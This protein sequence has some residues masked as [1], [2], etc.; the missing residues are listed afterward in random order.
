MQGQL[1]VN[2]AAPGELDVDELA[3]L[4]TADVSAYLN[5]GTVQHIL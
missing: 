5:G 1:V 3:A 2:S 4:Y